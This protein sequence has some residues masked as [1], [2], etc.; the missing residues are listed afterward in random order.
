MCFL[1]FKG[2][3]LYVVFGIWFVV[4]GWGVGDGGGVV[5]VCVCCSLDFLDVGY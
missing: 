3:V 2:G 4:V 5:G 1:R